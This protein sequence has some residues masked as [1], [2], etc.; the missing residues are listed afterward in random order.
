MNP[1]SIRYIAKVTGI[2]AA[3][4]RLNIKYLLDSMPEL[5]VE[6]MKNG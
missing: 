1:I 2:N 6:I 4:I 3:T 5:K